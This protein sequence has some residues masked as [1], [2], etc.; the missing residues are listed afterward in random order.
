MEPTPENNAALIGAILFL[1]SGPVSEAYIAKTSGLSPEDVAL[2]LNRLCTELEASCHGFAPVQSG[3]G[4]IL[5]PKVEI[6]EQ[7]KAH[8]GQ[9]SEMKLSRAAMETLSII[10]YSQPIT[11]AE[12]EAI[13]GVSADGMIRFLLS[14]DLIR[15][16]GKKDAPGKP[17]LYATT[18]EFLKYFKLGSINDLPK[19]DDTDLKRFEKQE[20]EQG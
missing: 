4:W 3:G 7:L 10:A 13:R 2:A 16:A 19:L 8:Y 18:D 9:K 6:W 20:G 14:R 5:A 12:V 17:L 11:R 1:E 15:E